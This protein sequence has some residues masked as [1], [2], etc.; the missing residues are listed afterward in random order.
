M[1][2]DSMGETMDKST[3]KSMDKKMKD[4]EY[5]QLALELAQKGLGKVNPNP[6]VGAVIVKDQ[7]IIGQGFHETYAGPH[8]EPNAFSSCMEDCEGATLYVTLE[9]CCHHGKTPPCTDLIIKNKISRVII[10][11]QDPNPL[12]AGMGIKML[13]ENGITVEIGVLEKECTQLNSVFFHYIQTK[14]PF[15]AMKYAMTL[16][17]KIATYSGQSKWITGI[18]TRE[19]VHLLRHTY[20]AIMVG[21][22]TVIMD[23]PA[24]TCRLKEGAGL[25]PV[26]I[27]CDTMLRIPLSSKLVQTAKEIPTYIACCCEDDEKMNK[28]ADSGCQILQ[29]RKEEGHVSLPHLMNILHNKTI[30][31]ILLEGG[32]TLNFSALKSGIVNK[33][34]AYIAP[35]LFGGENA[36]TPVGGKGISDLETAFSLGNRRLTIFG[37]DILLE[38]DVR[39]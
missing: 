23:D 8:A 6:L 21:V 34:Y 14:T 33:V 20:T 24:L 17:G 19:H 12:V 18:H 38:Y 3:G 10:G 29:T 27:V 16:D 35:K 37:E 36:K 4:Q 9:P 15:V 22:D 30:D 13:K 7:R 1:A 26:R 32:A 28:L 5:M 25:D 31:C 11:T 39:R 2:I